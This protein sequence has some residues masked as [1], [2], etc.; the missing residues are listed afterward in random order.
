[1]KLGALLAIAFVPAIASADY[2]IVKGAPNVDDQTFARQVIPAESAPA[3]NVA[4]SKVVYLNRGGITVAPGD[5]DARTNKSTLAKQQVQIPAW[6]TTDTTW[7]ATVACMK[8]LFAPFDISIVT[9]DPGPAVQHI[10]AVFGGAPQMLGMDNNVMGVAPFKSDCGIL[11]N[12]IVFTFTSNIPQDARLACE[13]QAQEVAHAYG[14][15]HERLPNDPLTYMRYDGNRSF[16]NQLAECGEDKARMCGVTGSPSCRGKQNSVQLLFD[17]LGAKAV[18]GDTTPP[19]VSIKSPAN[20]ATVEPGFMVEVAASDNTRVTLASIYIDDV[21]SGS[22]S[23]APW[24]L[25]A[26]ANMVRGIRKIKVEVTD[27]RNTRTTQIEVNVQGEAASDASDD[28]SGGCATSGSWSWL[29]LLA[30]LGLRRRS[31][32]AGAAHRHETIR[33]SR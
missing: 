14:L 1:M 27:G 19:T 29:V 33:S 20:G 22:A 28:L 31:S 23:V 25:R 16:Q 5:N 10:E 24:S 3:G 26:P 21:P 18:A 12:A 6:N 32:K 11:E 30:L 13:I 15:D 8:E 2:R 9:T 7:N 4:Q 17:R